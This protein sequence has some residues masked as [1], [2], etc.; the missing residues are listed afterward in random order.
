MKIQVLFTS[1]FPVGNAGSN[2]VYYLCKGLIESG[3]NVE[4]LITNPTESFGNER[5][6][7]PN[8]IYENVPFRYINNELKRNKNIVLR[9]LTDIYC[10]IATILQ[11]CRNQD[12][13]DFFIVIGTLIDFRLFLPFL[14]FCNKAKILLEINEYPYV[15]KTNN[16][17]T[18]I[19]RF[20]LFRCIFP[21][22]DGFI[23]I[24]ETLYNLVNQYKS[25]KAL[26]IVI[27]ILGDCSGIKTPCRPP[28]DVPYIIHAGSLVENK[29][30][31][32]GMLKAFKIV[33]EQFEQPIKFVIT[34][35]IKG[36]IEYKKVADFISKNRLSNSVI[37]TG[38]LSK[39][40]LD[41]YL[42]YSSLAI[43]N[44]YNNIQNRF[45]F[46]T[47][48]SDYLKHEVPLIVTSVGESVKYL[49]DGI[50]AYIVEPGDV[51]LLASKIIQAIENSNQ[52]KSM[53][54]NAK[55]LVKKEFNY[56][57]QGPRLF[58]MLYGLY[59]SST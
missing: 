53:A 5:N 39:D 56:S 8:G 58:H 20:F 45:C 26:S 27:P 23:V 30:G 59:T 35:N 57:Y 2:R 19:K 38:F 12:R 24:S 42:S 29:D 7:H 40:E 46:P 4:L 51:G 32:L 43:I 36:S 28:I 15:T 48:L 6:L 33:T 3:A 54:S 34:G 17:I 49:K 16:I 21:F 55:S 9:K 25:S 50:N 14:K 44:K 10:H 47:K 22:Y 52:S 18:I 31:I 41:C 37:F 11:V 1:S 13:F